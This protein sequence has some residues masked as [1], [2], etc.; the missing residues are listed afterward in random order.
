MLQKPIFEVDPIVQHHVI[1]FVVLN[2]IYNIVCLYVKFMVHYTS[3]KLV[4]KKVQSKVWRRI[5]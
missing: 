4:H 2:V 3:C 5:E 1:R